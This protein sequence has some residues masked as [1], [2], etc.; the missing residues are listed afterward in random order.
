[1]HE[2]PVEWLECWRQSYVY[3]ESP[4]MSELF[5]LVEQCVEDAKRE[6]IPLRELSQAAGGS[7]RSYLR[8]AI[9]FI[10]SD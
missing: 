5:E 2:S 1:M 3:A 8:E 9:K 7:L 4:V 6:N 10:G